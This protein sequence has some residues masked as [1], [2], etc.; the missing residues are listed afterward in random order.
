MMNTFLLVLTSFALT[1]ISLPLMRFL[2]GK[3]KLERKNFRGDMIPAG[4]GFVLT[5]AAIPVYALMM[6][7]RYDLSRAGLFL[8]L[9]LGFG[10][11]GLVDDVYGNRSAGGFSGHFGMLR[12]G[13]VSTGLIKAV[14]GGIL[15][16]LV[17]LV[18][19]RFDLVQGFINGLV[20]GF[21]ANLL[22][23]LDLRPGRA[24]SCFWVGVLLLALC[25]RQN[26]SLL[27]EIVP[28][29]VPA[30]F[31]TMLDRSA[32]V[33]LGDAGSNVLGA[34]AGLLAVYSLGLPGKLVILVLLIGVH[35][36][37][38]KYSISRLIE[39]T[40]VLRSLDRL[41]GER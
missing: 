4:F 3:W 41:L 36:Y 22:N 13:K 29:V 17:G 20:I 30:I 38:E 35:V 27:M 7:L 39:E 15:S 28:I 18:I 12:H 1:A 14:V 16:L 33:M 19:A 5:I 6:V 32:R 31:L 24:V 2:A 9:V 25:G 10:I 26:T 21:S 40:R 11:V 8:I 23:L 34:V 37:A